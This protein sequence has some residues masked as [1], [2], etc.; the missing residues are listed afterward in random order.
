ML[1]RP[2]F[3]HKQIIVISSDDRKSLTLHNGNILITRTDPDNGSLEKL[4][5]LSCG[6]IFCIFVFGDVTI[7]TKIINELLAYNIRIYFL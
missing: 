7:T 4:T 2:D 3:E 5:Q 1:S 6:K